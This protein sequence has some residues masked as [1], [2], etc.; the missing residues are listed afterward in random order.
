VIGGV[1][2]ALGSVCL[3]ACSANP[4]TAAR[5]IDVDLGADVTA[6]PSSTATS[7][8]VHLV[9]IVRN[10]PLGELLEEQVRAAA[11]AG[12][13]LLVMTNAQRCRACS[14]FLHALADPAV[15]DALADVMVVR[16]DVA[17]Y[18]RDIPSLGLDSYVLPGFFLLDER[19]HARDGITGSEWD[20]DVPA[21]IAPVVGA[22]AHER[23]PN[24][25][26]P[27]PPRG[28]SR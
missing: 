14:R 26:A 4:T 12:E 15:R 18:P 11:D 21:N 10:A 28:E 16:V 2:R 8:P 17:R 7:K 5:V 23:Y 6:E 25:K 19:G 24:R 27:M 3:A 9:R 1:F 20:D 22:F 13:R